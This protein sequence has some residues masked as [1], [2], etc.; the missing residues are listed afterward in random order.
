MVIISKSIFSIPMVKNKYHNPVIPFNH[1]CYIL[2][3]CKSG[4]SA[5]VL[6]NAHA[7]CSHAYRFTLFVGLPKGVCHSH[8]SILNILGSLQTLITPHST[9]VATTCFFHIGGFTTGINT[10]IKHQTY[11][12]VRLKPDTQT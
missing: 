1:F 10:L 9:M 7:Q 11:Y 4:N 2:S 3:Y 8:F 6:F 5:I 12:H